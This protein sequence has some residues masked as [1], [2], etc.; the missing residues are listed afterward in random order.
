[1]SAQPRIIVEGGVVA[2]GDGRALED[3]TVVVEGDRVAEVREDGTRPSP[4]PSD[5]RLDADGRLVTPGLV[6]AWRRLPARAE[7]AAAQLV[8]AL[9]CGAVGSVVSVAP[10]AAEAVHRFATRLGTRLILGVALSPE[11]PGV[12]LEAFRRLEPHPGR[13]L[14]ALSLGRAALLEEAV[15]DEVLA[16]IDGSGTPLLVEAAASD[17][18]LQRVWHR[19]RCRPVERLR[20]LGVLSERTVVGHGSLVDADEIDTLAKTGAWLSICPRTANRRGF[21]A[22]VARLRDRGV[23]VALGTGDAGPDPWVEIDALEARWTDGTTETRRRIADLATG[24]RALLDHLLGATTGTLA[25]GSAADLVVHRYRPASPVDGWAWP[26]VAGRV[27]G[28]DWVV[29]GGR[30]LVRDGRLLGVDPAA[31]AAEARRS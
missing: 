17:A 19:H 9:Q 15:L 27:R 14:P 4:S 16:E 13:V 29:V 28:A 30:V 31:V 23:R 24:G 10:E 11:R 26:Q 22:P 20:R 21:L 2:T 12:G 1:V 3:A 25:V 7:A 18:E 8:E 6:D 5:W